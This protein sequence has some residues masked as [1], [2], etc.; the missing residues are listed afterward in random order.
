MLIVKKLALFL[1]GLL[2]AGAS[3]LIWLDYH[4]GD[5]PRLERVLCRIGICSTDVLAAESREQLILGTPESIQRAVAG[6][7]EVLRRDA[8]SP[9]RWCDLGEALFAAGQADKATGCYR[10]ALELG[11]ELVP[12]LWRAAQHCFLVKLNREGLQ[13]LSRILEKTE[14]LDAEVFGAFTFAR[15]TVREALDNAIPVKDP[16]A[17]RAYFHHLIRAAPLPDMRAAWD[18]LLARSMPDDP[19]AAAWLDLLIKNKDYAGARDAWS[20]YLGGRKGPYLQSEFLF[21]GDFEAEPTG[22]VFD[23][24]IRGPASVEVARDNS[25]A[26]SG[27]WSLKLVFSGQENVSFQHVTQAAVLPPG[28]YRFSAALR[29]DGITTDQGVGFLITDAES[30]ARL[31]VATEA[32]TGTRAWG[33]V[34]TEFRVGPETRLV[35]V[36]VIRRTSRKIDSKIRGTAWIDDVRLA[37]LKD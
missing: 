5:Y 37:R 6:F 1:G 36:Q 18:W 32:W 8:A 26:H 16:R 20:A 17:G 11:P 23:W 7:T 35:R 19:L 28:S 34:E 21:N 25:S 10:R 22:A 14:A 33:R 9:Y 29:T 15:V 24:R 13:H 31:S 2:V 30:S 3:I 12:I 27:T 4:A